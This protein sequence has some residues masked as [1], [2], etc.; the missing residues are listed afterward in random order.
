MIVQRS[1]LLSKLDRLNL[2]FSAEIPVNGP[3]EDFNFISLVQSIW[4]DIIISGKR[5]PGTG[6]SIFHWSK[7][8]IHVRIRNRKRGN[9]RIK[10][11][12]HETFSDQIDA[13]SYG[14]D[15]RIHARGRHHDGPGIQEIAYYG[16]GREYGPR[17]KAAQHHV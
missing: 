9:L 15:R 17:N 11:G 3:T 13:D 12:T 16:T 14:D 7:G 6:L 5:R 4:I 2:K 10:E 8:R 1:V